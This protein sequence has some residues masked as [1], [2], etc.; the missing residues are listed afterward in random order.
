MDICCLTSD[1]EGL[2]NLLMEAAAAGLPVV[3]TNCGGSVELIDDGLTGFLVSCDDVANMARF[4]DVLLTNPDQR[5]RMGLAARQKMCRQASIH[6]M[7]TSLMTAYDETLR[8]N[9]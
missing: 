6:Q 1:T 5:R 4:I 9:G 7:A 2:P 3:S 8:A